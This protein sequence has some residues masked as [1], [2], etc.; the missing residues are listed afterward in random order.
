M[1]PRM[2]TVNLRSFPLAA[3][4]IYT[5]NH[6]LKEGSSQVVKEVLGIQVDASYFSEEWHRAGATVS[7]NLHVWDY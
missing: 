5:S 3:N 6:C 7:S 2:K 4:L 1:N